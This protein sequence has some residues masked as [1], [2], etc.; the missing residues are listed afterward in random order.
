MGREPRQEEAGLTYHL[1]AKGN[2]GSMV[3][4]TPAHRD[5]FVRL[6]LRV[7]RRYGWTCHAY[8]VLGN[9]VH[10]I[11]T[12][13]DANLSAGMRDLLGHYARWY[14]SRHP[15]RGHVFDGRYR[16]K[17]IVSEA[18]LAAAIEYVT[19]NAATAGLVADAEHW[20]WAWSSGD[21]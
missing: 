16:S 11:I 20:A 9:H 2:E 10:L 18:Y 13:P 14:R 21:S 3:F 15:A 1:M 19:S 4:A 5:V 12:T 6:L 7:C 8:C 17:V